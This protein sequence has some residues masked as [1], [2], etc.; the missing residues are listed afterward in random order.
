[1]KIWGSKIKRL[2]RVKCKKL[3]FYKKDGAPLRWA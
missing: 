1:M 2:A 3:C